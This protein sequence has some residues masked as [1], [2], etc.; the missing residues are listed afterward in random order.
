MIRISLFTFF[1][2]I[3][4]LLSGQDTVNVTDSK[5][6]RQGFWRKTDT[7]GRVV[8]EGRFS[9][10]YPS[11]EF[12]YFYPNG[13]IK[14]IS[15]VSSGGKRAVTISYFPNG[16]K[17]AAGNYLNEK[18]DS[19]WQFFSE[20]NGTLVSEETYKSGIIQGISRVFYPE[21]GLSEFQE[22]KNGILEGRWEQ[23][24]LD[25][26]LKLQGTFKA[27]EKEGLFKTFFMSGQLMMTGQYNQG[28]QDGTWVFY[29]DKG[30][31]TEKEF[32]KNGKLIKTEPGTD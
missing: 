18:K 11:G 1:M 2:M 9:D 4:C 16:N 25:G 30:I 14:T 10:G 24:Y 26:K 27:G 29:N 15:K 6:H 7:A 22:Y 3:S 8:Y 31:V 13:K 12:R 28:H 20:S 19:T 5:G 23:Y 21:G 32:Y 17:M